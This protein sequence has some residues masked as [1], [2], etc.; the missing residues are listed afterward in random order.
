MEMVGHQFTWERGRGTEDFMEI[1]LDRVVTT[2]QWLN[3]F[4][5]AKLYNLKVT[6]SDHSPIILVPEV[7]EKAQGI[8]K[9]HYENARLTE[10][11]CMQIVLDNWEEG[12]E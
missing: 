5:F 4:H 6:S 9:F 7:C 3:M 2:I 10:P 8:R 1:R 12:V 11:M